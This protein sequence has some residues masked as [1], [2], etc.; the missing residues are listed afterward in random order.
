MNTTNHKPVT[1]V[2][3]PRDRFTG[4]EQ[5]I[6][7]LYLHTDSSLFEL[8]ILDLGYPKKVI[9][10]A[11]E[12]LKNKIE[13][14]KDLSNLTFWELE[15][16]ADHQ[17]TKYTIS[18]EDIKAEI[19]NDKELSDNKKGYLESTNEA[20]KIKNEMNS[21]R[22]KIDRQYPNASEAFKNAIFNRESWALVNKY[23]SAIEEASLYENSYKFRMGEKELIWDVQEKE[24]KEKRE[25]FKDL[26]KTKFEEFS[27]DLAFEQESLIQEEVLKLN[28]KYSW[29]ATSK[30]DKSGDL[31]F[32]NSDWKEINRTKNFSE[33]VENTYTIETDLGDGLWTEITVIDK[34]TNEIKSSYI[35]WEW[36]SDGKIFGGV[37]IK[38]KEGE[39]LQRGDWQRNFNLKR[40]DKSTNI[41]RDTNNPWNITADWLSDEEAGRLWRGLWASWTYTSPN[42]REYF[43]FNNL[44]SWVLALKGMVK[45]Q[46]EGNSSWATP[47][48]SLEQY[49]IWYER[50]P[51]TPWFETWD[52]QKAWVPEWYF[53]SIVKELGAKWW[54]RLDV[55]NP[56][57]VATAI[58][59][60]EGFWDISGVDWGKPWNQSEIAMAQK[61]ITGW[62]SDERADRLEQYKELRREELTHNE[63]I[64][65]VAWRT[66]KD[67]YKDL[68]DLRK[69]FRSEPAVKRY[70]DRVDE[71]Q[72]I[73]QIVEGWASWP[74]DM[75]LVF[76]FMKW[77][78]PTSVVRESEY[79]LAAESAGALDRIGSLQLIQKWQNWEILTDTQKDEF[80]NITKAVMNVSKEQYNTILKNYQVI[81]M[82]NWLDQSQISVY[83][84][85]SDNDLNSW[86]QIYTDSDGVSYTEEQIFEDWINQGLTEEEIIQWMDVSIPK[87]NN[88]GDV[89]NTPRG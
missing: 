62:T 12:V 50:W 80:V 24:M 78:D 23:N 49:I 67:E 44:N 26:F 57:D 74:W 8:I 52:W 59:R 75:A 58:A 76:S 32:F 47:K 34:K 9:D 61:N 88:W 63:A 87:S 22:W 35:V 84:W 10:L 82:K 54:E 77:L 29:A 31:V 65:I 28:K 72:K 36:P 41:A 21:L 68:K 11:K 5:C 51:W 53:R 40:P 30:V 64:N 83:D 37:K 7:T 3:S 39:I 69:D 14:T 60:A 6:E 79:A 81:A 70:V 45:R 73:E 85:I 46:V 89:R 18:S 15:E 71:F 19:E 66:I 4:L 25:I 38:S 20:L 1:V 17:W 43:V 16:I 33:K 55:F 48:M 86:I 42:W 56:E 2:I 27:A 13:E